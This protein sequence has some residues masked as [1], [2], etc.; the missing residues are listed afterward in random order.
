MATSTNRPF[1][2][3]V[4]A[5][6]AR[7]AAEWKGIATRAE[8]LGYS[9]L[10][11]PDI[12]GPILAP[13]AALGVAAASTSTLHVGNWV[14]ANDFRHPLLVA[15]EAATLD[16]LSQMAVSS[17]VWVLVVTTTT[18][19]VSVWNQVQQAFASANSAN[20]SRFCARSLP[21]SP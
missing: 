6:Q 7:S 16:L 12:T 10:M 3:G 4:V 18:T 13:F 1:R 2:F 8:A 14:L 15:R 20:R 19:P 9:T 21:A 11:L 5:P 17:S